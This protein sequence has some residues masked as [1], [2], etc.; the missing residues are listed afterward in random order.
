MQQGRPVAQ[1]DDADHIAQ[2]QFAVPRLVSFF[3][4]WTLAL[5]ATGAPNAACD[6]S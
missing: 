6:G 1:A 4:G 3:N 5:A 2:R